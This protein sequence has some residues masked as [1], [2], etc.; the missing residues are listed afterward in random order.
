MGTRGNRIQLYI[1]MGTFFSAFCD[2]GPLRWR[3]FAMMALCDGGPLRWRT[4]T[5]LPGANR[6][7]NT[8]QCQ[9][10]LRSLPTQDVYVD[11]Q[12]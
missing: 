5:L 2:G 7:G 11:H 8:H 9:C 1:T 6:R 10:C 3:T 4:G 12:R